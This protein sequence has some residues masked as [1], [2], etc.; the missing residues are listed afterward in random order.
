MSE[1]L[2]ELSSVAMQAITQQIANEL[3]VNTQQVSSAIQLL[4]EG[5]TVPFIARYRKEVTGG[6]SD[7]H[8]RDLEQRLQYL[9]ELTQRR[10]SILDSI[11]KQGKLTAE[12]KAAIEQ[13]ET[14]TRLEDLYLPYKPK[15]RTKGEIAKEQGLEPL[16]DAL[17]SDPRQDPQTLAA[18]YVSQAEDDGKPADAKAALD[19]ARAILMERFAEQADLLQAL[20]TLLSD[21]GRIA[22]QKIEGA[23]DKGEKF[24]DYYEF[25][26]PIKTIPSHRALALF[27]GRKQKVLRLDI[28]LPQAADAKGLDHPAIAMIARHVGYSPSG[29]AADAWLTQVIEWTWKVKLS[30]SIESELLQQLKA[31]ADEASIQVFQQNLR[32]VLMASPAGKKR[33]LGLDPGIRTGVKLAI[34]DETGQLLHTETLFPHE[35]KKQWEPSKVSLVQLSEQYKVD[36]IAVGNG[37]ASRETSKLVSEAIAAMTSV[38]P[39]RVMVNEAGA[40]VYSASEFA[41]QE[42]PDLDVSYRGAV[43]I[44]RRLQDPLAELVKIEPKSIGV[45]QYQHDVNQGKLAQSLEV[46]VEDCVN[47]V[48]VDVNTASIPL[49]ARVAGLNTA[50]AGN[51]VMY[52]NKHGRFESREQLKQIPRLGERTFEQAAGFLRILDAQNPLDRSA[53]HPEAYSI[54]ESMAEKQQKPIEALV[55][56]S[57]IIRQINAEEFVSEQF[58]LPTIRD[59]IDELEKPGRDPRD[60]FEVVE[61]KEGVETIKDLR[62]DM[63]LTGVVTNVTKFGAFVDIGVHQDGLVHISEL[64]DGFVSN[65]LDVVKTGETVKVRVMDAD[66]DR[67]R[68]NLSMRLDKPSIAKGGQKARS[69]NEQ[70][71]SM[72]PSETGK[73]SSGKKVQGNK[74]YGKK[75]SGKSANSSSSMGTL[76][77]VFA[78]AGYFDKK[79]DDKSKSK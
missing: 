51:I 76:A 38:K 61:F 40:S 19:G 33:I 27:R 54:V 75:A 53:V 36:L 58:G 56:N 60:A 42:F 12:L 52:R 62:E 63:V 49:L 26:E 3:K 15:K 37:T 71:G 5:A 24:K 32:N 29:L 9:R 39:K 7:T 41:A 47:A 64:R 43:S 28:Q 57:E 69:K 68:I 59:I 78:Q 67:N 1:N 22:S 18:G 23:Q 10:V 73:K 35:P 17:W 25:D 6:L 72:N 46:A 21:Q 11:E 4:D 65:P 48:G 50:V 30:L 16:A 34:I 66:V 44:A 77:S 79:T 2:S 20:R 31:E 8:L 55:N 74:P 14:K 13:A 70:K 45:G